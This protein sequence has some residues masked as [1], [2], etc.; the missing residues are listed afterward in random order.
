VLYSDQPTATNHVFP[1][2]SQT[3]AKLHSG[4]GRSNSYQG[5]FTLRY[6]NTIGVHSFD[7]TAGGEQTVSNNEDLSVYWTDQR[8][9]GLDDWW[10]FNPSTLTRHSRMIKDGTK[11]SFFGRFNYDID[12]KYL[13]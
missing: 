12:K 8:I 3:T 6:G 13:L 7:I 2:I 11:R 4:L 1:A 10:A 5:F 9:P